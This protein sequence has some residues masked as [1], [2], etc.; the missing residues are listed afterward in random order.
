M[1]TTGTQI[2]A[3]RALVGWSQSDLADAAGLH[4]NAVAYWEAKASIKYSRFHSG[5]GSSRIVRTLA[6]AGVTFIAEPGPGVCLGPKPQFP[7][8]IKGTAPLPHRPSSAASPV[9]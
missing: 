7:D 4:E 8:A 9:A 3:A 2:K 6:S 5:S 1:L